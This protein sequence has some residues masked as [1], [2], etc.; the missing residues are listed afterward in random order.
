M[1]GRQ[2]IER[3]TFEEVL[4]QMPTGVD[5]AQAPSGKTTV[6]NRQAQQWT[7]QRLGWSMRTERDEGQHGALLGRRTHIVGQE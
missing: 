3:A 1:I 7:G 5:I 6:F 4:R 2:E